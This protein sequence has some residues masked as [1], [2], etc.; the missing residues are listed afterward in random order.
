MKGSQRLVVV[1]NHK[2]LPPVIKSREAEAG[3]LGRSLFQRL[4]ELGAP[5]DMLQVRVLYLAQA[6]PQH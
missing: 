2:Q 1:G 6:V 5:S 4:M 3:G